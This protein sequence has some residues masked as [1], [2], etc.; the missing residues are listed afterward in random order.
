VILASAVLQSSV[1]EGEN[2]KAVSTMQ[3]NLGAINAVNLRQAHALVESGKT[4]GKIGAQISF[5]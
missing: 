4:I 5:W 2:M 1:T 3:T